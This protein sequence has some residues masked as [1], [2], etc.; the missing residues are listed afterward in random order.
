MTPD[1]G[2]IDITKPIVETDK[3]TYTYMLEIDKNRIIKHTDGVNAM[4]QAVYKILHTERYKYEIYDWNY[5]IEFADLFGRAK[6]YAYP[7][8]KR[9]ITEALLSD[10]RILSVENFKLE[11]GKKN[12]VAISFMVNTIF[13][14]FETDKEVNI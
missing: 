6:A 8:L 13:G 12:I 14:S 11:R 2:G 10:K 5:G 9:R 7:E 1:N 3:P 4:K